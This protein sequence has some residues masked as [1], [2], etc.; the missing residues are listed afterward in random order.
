MPTFPQ[1]R[2][3]KMGAKI[4]NNVPLGG[5]N[6]P[7]PA[8]SIGKPEGISETIPFSDIVSTNLQ[9]FHSSYVFN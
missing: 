5:T 3:L 4:D 2:N 1:H 8:P 6:P 7:P 9:E